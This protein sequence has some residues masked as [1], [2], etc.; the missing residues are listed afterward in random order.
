M[1]TLNPARYFKLDGEIGSIAPGRYADVLILES[2]TDFR[3]QRV[4]FEG[5]LVAENGALLQVPDPFDYP[6]YYLNSIELHRSLRPASLVPQVSESATAATVLVLELNRDDEQADNRAG[7]AELAVEAG[8]IQPDLQNDTI[9]L[10]VVERYGKNGNVGHGFCRGSG[11][12]SG[13]IATS[14]SISDSN[15]VVL[16]CDVE[17]MWTA[18]QEVARIQGGA[19]V[20]QGG[21]VLKSCALRL[22]GQMTDEP[23]E[24]LIVA[25]KGLVAEARRLGST[26]TNPILTLASTVL[27]SIPDL[28]LTDTGYVDARTGKRAELVIEIRHFGG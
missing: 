25:M 1:A 23:Y 10:S 28:G 9:Y 18:V 22:G 12:R 21:E 2:L 4:Y 16:G 13:A 5:E 6:S 7:T 14:L 19:A 11:L 24:E 20:A 17:S 3:P 8:V 27:M 15:I 26:L